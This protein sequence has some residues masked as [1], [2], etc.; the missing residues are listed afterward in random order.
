M[1]VG[2]AIWVVFIMCFSCILGY[3]FFKNLNK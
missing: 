2:I 3:I 1:V